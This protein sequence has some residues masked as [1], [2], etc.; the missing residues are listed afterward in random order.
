MGRQ[1]VDIAQRDIAI[2]PLHMPQVPTITT[3]WRVHYLHDIPIAQVR[4]D[5]LK[6]PMPAVYIRLTCSDLLRH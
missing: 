3:P 2:S 4:K 1:E 5:R 6:E